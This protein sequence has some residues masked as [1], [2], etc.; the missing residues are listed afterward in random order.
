MAFED[1]YLVSEDLEVATEADVRAAEAALHTSFPLGY[2]D[3]VTTLG[4]GVY[5]YIVRVALPTQILAEYAGDQA[6]WAEYADMH[7]DYYDVIPLRRLVETI[8]FAT[9]ADGAN[10]VFHPDSPAALYLLED[11]YAYRAGTTLYE[12]LDWIVQSGK[13]PPKDRA[14]VLT[15]SGQ[16]VERDFRYFES[17]RNRKLVQFGGALES[18]FDQARDALV[19][20]ARSNPTGMTCVLHREENPDGGL[21]WV[22]LLVREYAAEVRCFAPMPEGNQKSISTINLTY[23]STRQTEGLKLLFRMLNSLGYTSYG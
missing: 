10:V 14:V 15:S 8:L 23:D 18:S 21:E 4:A 20:L 7:E 12:L 11:E 16:F 2:S 13:A 1:V 3:Y 6:M 9:T 17:Y 5:N 19:A 22:Q